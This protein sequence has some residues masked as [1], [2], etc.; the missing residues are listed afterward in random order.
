[1]AKSNALFQPP[2]DTDEK[3]EVVPDETV[4]AR[5]RTV[6]QMLVLS[7]FNGETREKSYLTFSHGRNGWE[8]RLSDP[9]NR[10]SVT[11]AC[12]GFLGGLEALEML[13]EADS[14]NWFYW[15]GNGKK[16]SKK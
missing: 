16:K 13:A 8:M 10:R 9:E 4:E 11:V 2:S 3:V 6:H 5:A 12:N 14:V 15:S 7:E 1:M